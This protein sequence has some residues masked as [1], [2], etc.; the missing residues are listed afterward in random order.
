MYMCIS[1]CCKVAMN[2]S[3]RLGKRGKHNQLCFHML[4]LS[5]IGLC[6]RANCNDVRMARH[7]CSATLSLVINLQL[8]K[9]LLAK[10]R[11]LGIIQGRQAKF[12]RSQ[13]CASV[14]SLVRKFVLRDGQMSEPSMCREPGCMY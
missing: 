6:S 10:A 8:P 2:A 5:P 11:T 12:S 14:R 9:S 13:T 4:A 1:F 7:P 3:Q